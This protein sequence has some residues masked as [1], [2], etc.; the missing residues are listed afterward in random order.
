M[1]FDI[2][3]LTFEMKKV[4][5]A[6]AL[7]LYNMIMAQSYLIITHYQSEN[8]SHSLTHNMDLG[9]ASA[10]KNLLLKSKI[11]LEIFIK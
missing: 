5:T 7:I 9:D 8:I 3:H 1:T 11:Y 6:L 10:S 4:L 2:Q